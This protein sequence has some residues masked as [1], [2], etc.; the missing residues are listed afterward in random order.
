[1]QQQRYLDLI[2][3]QVDEREQQIVVNDVI[4]QLFDEN[5]QVESYMYLIVDMDHEFFLIA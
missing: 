5:V 2:D 1:M 4:N 3:F